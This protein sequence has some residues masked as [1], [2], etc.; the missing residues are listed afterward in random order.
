[1]RSPPETAHCQLETKFIA[2]EPV[3]QV[4]VRETKLW[5][6]NDPQHGLIVT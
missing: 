5:M 2:G 1:M 4:G 3:N 6:S